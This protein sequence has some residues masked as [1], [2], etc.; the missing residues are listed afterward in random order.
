MHKYGGGH[1]SS[2][3]LDDAVLLSDVQCNGMERELSLCPNITIGGHS[4]DNTS[5]AGVICTKD[6][7]MF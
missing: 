5:S 7:G 6:F 1:N 4:C 2:F 3:N